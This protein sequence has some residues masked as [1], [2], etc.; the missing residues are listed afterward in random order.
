MPKNLIL[1]LILTR[2]GLNLVPK[3]FFCGFYLSQM[4]YIVASYQCMQFQGKLITKN[5]K[6][7]KNLVSDL[8]LATLAQIWPQNF[9]WILPLLDLRS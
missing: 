5:E 2:F 1:N 8:I 4:L 7:A 3:M 9:L 6:M